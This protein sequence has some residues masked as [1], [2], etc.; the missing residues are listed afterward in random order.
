MGEQNY[1]CDECLR[2][3]TVRFVWLK[4]R[5]V[6]CPKC[7]SKKVSEIAKSCSCSGMSKDS[8]GS[9]FT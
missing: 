7:G 5:G 2:E 9:F 4:P 8:K 1:F 3:F 6:T